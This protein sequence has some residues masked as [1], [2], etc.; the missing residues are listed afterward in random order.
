MIR[1]RNKREDGEMPDHKDVTERRQ[2]ERYEQFERQLNNYINNINDRVGPIY[3]R[4][5]KIIIRLLLITGYIL[6]LST[7][8]L[9]Q[10]DFE[11][12]NVE[13]SQEKN[14]LKQENSTLTSQSDQLRAIREEYFKRSQKN[15][16]DSAQLDK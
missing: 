15:D 1:K 2:K 14:P 3:P 4:H 8:L 9:H 6:M 7:F 16:V 12:S 10:L 13:K 5:H 11:S